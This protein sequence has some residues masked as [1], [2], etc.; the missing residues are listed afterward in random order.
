MNR[1]LYNF[2]VKLLN[3]ILFKL[4]SMASHKMLQL[5]Q[6]ILVNFVSNE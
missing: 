6:L 4:K 2:T 1:K 3:F 5:N